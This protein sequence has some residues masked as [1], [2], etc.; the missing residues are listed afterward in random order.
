MHLPPFKLERYFARYEFAVRHLLCS[1]DCESMTI[2]DLLS[3]EAGAGKA[4]E[5]LWLGYTES[6]GAPAL[7]QAISGL[8]DAIGPDQVLVHSGA[9]EAIYLFMHAALSPG[10]HLIVHWPC[11]QS[12]Y[13]VARSI[14]CEVTFWLAKEDQGWALNLND[15]VGHIRPATRAVIVNTP[16][17]PTGWLM[18]RD[19]FERLN[20]QLDQREIL[21]FSDEV[22]RESEY[23]A[24]ER[25]P[26]ACD[27]SQR[28]VSLGVMS[29]TY[30]LPGLRIG[31]V[32]TRHAAIQARMAALKDYTT[33]C[34]SGPSE[35]LAAIALRHRDRLIR[36]NLD[37]ITTN[38]TLLDDFF[39]RHPRTF[40]W[41]RPK[42][43]PIAFVRLIGRQVNRFCRE[44]VDKKGVLLLPGDLYGDGGNHFRIGFGRQSM[45][46]ALAALAQFVESLNP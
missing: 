17:N 8:Y 5:Q 25:L 7:R 18:P 30:G 32:A 11:Y 26:A 36:R 22:Y 45:P 33:I 12:L 28:A 44:L 2:Q 23:S 31:W 3:L 41:V 27:I 15:L 6:Q 35:F 20:R 19:E 9:E 40:T 29:K 4:F 1:S 37:I 39:Q 16:H 42:A 24:D 10:D 13:E 34:N 21:L 43:G 38:L 14:G 46:A